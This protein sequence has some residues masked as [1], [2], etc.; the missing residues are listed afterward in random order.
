MSNGC[1]SV[2]SRR[3]S[4]GIFTCLPFVKTA[5]TGVQATTAS[6]GRQ[7]QNGSHPQPGSVS[8]AVGCHHATNKAPP[9]HTYGRLAFCE[10]CPRKA[11][12]T[13]TV[14][15]RIRSLTRK[16]E[17]EKSASL[18]E[19]NCQGLLERNANPELECARL[20]T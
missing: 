20:A 12:E 13:T 2:K 11:N 9:G 3:L 1:C 16:K 15:Q 8:G 7:R 19:T 6:P 10:M 17:A 18:T 5:G 4:G 14:P